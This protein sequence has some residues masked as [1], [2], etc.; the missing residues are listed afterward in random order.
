MRN[1]ARH[2]DLVEIFPE[3]L[4]GYGMLSLPTKGRYF[5]ILYG[6][7]LLQNSDNL[8]VAGRCL[9]GDKVSHAALRSMMA[10]IVTGKGAGVA[11]AVPN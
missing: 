1:Q 5:Q 9:S 7:L 10:C 4:D 11:E 8:L 2:D 3:Y 6:I